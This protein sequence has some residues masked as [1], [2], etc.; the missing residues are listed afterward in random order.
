[1]YPAS[2]A[3]LKWRI[4]MSFRVTR[5]ADLPDITSVRSQRFPGRANDH[6]RPDIRPLVDTSG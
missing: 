2:F 3:Y 5:R 1:M 4:P 6:K